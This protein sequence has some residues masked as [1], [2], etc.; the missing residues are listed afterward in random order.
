MSDVILY[1]ALKENARLTK[2][3]TDSKLSTIPATYF[4]S[5]QSA[6]YPYVS[7]TG[8]ANPLCPTIVS[9]WEEALI[10]NIKTGTTGIK[11]CTTAGNWRC[12]FCCAFTV[13]A[14]VT[15]VQFQ[16]WG[17]GGGTSQNCCCG[18]APF[19]PSG[20]YALVQMNVTAGEIYTVCAG[21]AYCCCGTQTTPGICG[22]PTWVTGPGLC[23]CAD[24]GISCY[25]FW[26][27][28]IQSTSCGCA[29]PDPTSFGGNS[30]SAH[31]CSGWNFCYDTFD[32]QTIVCHAF[33]RATWRVNCAGT[34]RNFLCWGSNG[35]WPH[36]RVG[37]Q[38]N[39]LQDSCSF[40]T[41]VVG[42]Q[43]CICAEYW[44]SGVTCNPFCRAAVAGFL[45][46][47]GAGG[48]AGRVFGGC[49]A[50]GGDHGRMGMV[51]I[52]YGGF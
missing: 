2:E 31:G 48:Y 5:P 40:S 26:N 44:S 11:V 3:Y 49:N 17:P 29:I 35:L 45:Q 24:S 43:N 52:S 12:G 16:L 14:G 18:G 7:A 21:C 13:P 42:F 25:C 50:C 1:A 23:V 28:D 51:C 10:P 38:G 4:T 39:C 34:G 6:G 30:C 9:L 36:M 41:P 47:P 15:R 19:G 20:A 22:G 33:S 8:A 27:A 32:D 46:I 37:G